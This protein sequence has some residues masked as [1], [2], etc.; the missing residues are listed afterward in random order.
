[1]FRCQCKGP[2]SWSSTLSTGVTVTWNATVFSCLFTLGLRLRKPK[3][4]LQC[5]ICG[6]CGYYNYDFEKYPHQYIWHSMRPPIFEYV[7]STRASSLWRVGRPDTYWSWTPYPSSSPKFGMYQGL[8]AERGSRPSLIWPHK[9]LYRQQ[10]DGLVTWYWRASHL[11][12]Q[13]KDGPH[14]RALMNTICD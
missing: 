14:F 2:S 8:S 12:R 1:M 7:S 4:C 11:C 5:C 9:L 6:L 10:I 13:K 3:V